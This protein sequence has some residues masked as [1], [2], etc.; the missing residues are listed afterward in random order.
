MSG[1]GCSGL[2]WGIIIIILIQD[3]AM[4][5]DWSEKAWRRQTEKE[6]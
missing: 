3:V 6:N 4:E 5:T 1:K 2:I